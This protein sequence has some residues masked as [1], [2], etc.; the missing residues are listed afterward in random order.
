[1]ITEFDRDESFKSRD[2]ASYDAVS[3][4]FDHFTKRFAEPIAQR[5]VAL[6]ELSPYETILDVGTG[7]GILALRAAEKMGS[8]GKVIG[9]DLSEGMLKTATRKASKGGMHGAVEFQRMDAEELRFAEGSFDA[10][11]SL[12]ALRHFPRPRVALKEMFRVLRPGGRVVIGVGSGP[13]VFSFNGMAAALRR[14]P[15]FLYKVQGRRLI[16]CEFLNGLVR[17]L[18]P[19][20][21]GREETE[22]TTEHA[23]LTESIPSLVRSAGFS[24]I[25]RSWVSQQAVIETPEEFWQLQVTFS[26]L[27]RKRVA[28][29]S[30]HR[31]DP[32]RKEFMETCQKVQSR[33][34]KL[35]Y[36][37]GALIVAGQRPLFDR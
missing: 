37:M 29:A 19:D 25:R 15:D 1:M 23:H 22:W 2:A 3:D 14:V 17:K 34:G 13:P 21:N 8:T 20:T 24:K 26:S 27:A 33:G 35:L 6:A 30:S 12:F 4:A 5:M 28:E 7:T 10:V 32:L 9:I 18:L 16:A 11:L 31:V 36:P